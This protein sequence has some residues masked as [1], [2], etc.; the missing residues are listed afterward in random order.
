MGI[1]NRRAGRLFCTVYPLILYPQSRSPPPKLQ[2][3]PFFCLEFSR[4]SKPSDHLRRLCKMV[5][6]YLS[7]LP[8]K[9]SFP[10]LISRE[11]VNPGLFCLL[12]LYQMGRIFLNTSCYHLC[13]TLEEVCPDTPNSFSACPV[14][15]LYLLPLGIS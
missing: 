4:T 13:I 6:S 5:H 12:A 8:V 11:L 7:P 9:L 10:R 1:L 15:T 2:L 3:I 14:D